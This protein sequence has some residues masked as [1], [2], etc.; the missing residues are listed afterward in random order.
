[1]KQC[2]EELDVMSA[3][4]EDWIKKKEVSTTL[5]HYTNQVNSIKYY[6]TKVP[7]EGKKKA[8]NETL[9]H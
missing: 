2:T 4:L 6:V 9:H 7:I 1:M 8:T 3:K 5:I